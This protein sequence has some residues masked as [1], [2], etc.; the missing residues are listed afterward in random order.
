MDPSG[1]VK[2]YC[3]GRPTGGPAAEISWRLGVDLDALGRSRP[4]VRRCSRTP[5]TSTACSSISRPTTAPSAALPVSVV[6]AARSRPTARRVDNLAAKLTLAA[7]ARR[8]PGV[9]FYHYG[10]LRLEA[11]DMIRAAL[12]AG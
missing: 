5:P 10:F 4:R 11:L 6:P 1:A 9:H 8:S 3:D 2:G 7:Q 12:E